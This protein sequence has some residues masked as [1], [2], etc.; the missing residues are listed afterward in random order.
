LPD[1]LSDPE[2]TRKSTIS[3]VPLSELPL[4]TA[5]HV[6]GPNLVD[7]LNVVIG[8]TDQHDYRVATK[9]EVHARALLEH[10]R[11][12]HPT[13]DY[14]IT[15]VQLKAYYRGWL[16]HNNET[17]VPWNLLAAEFRRV[18]G[19]KKRRTTRVNGKRH[20]IFF[21]REPRCEDDE[22]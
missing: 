5:H 16:I 14:A 8:L 6:Y 21:I 17:E 18:T 9:V 13:E 22:A 19:E 11:A 1:A 10:C 12:S 4:R 20:P 7:G 2:P 3:P 15:G